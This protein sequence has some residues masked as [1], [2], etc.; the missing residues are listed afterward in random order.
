MSPQSD[1]R[2]E[3]SRKSVPSPDILRQAYDYWF[4]ELSAPDHF[5]A[6]KAEIWFK[7]S[8]VTDTHIKEKFGPQL[9]AIANANWPM[10]EMARQERVGLVIFLDQ[11]PRNIFRDSADA[12]AYDPV[13]RRVATALSGNNFSEYFPVEQLFLLLPFEHSESLA[14]QEQ[15]VELMTA[16]AEKAP[17]E[18]T[19]YPIA[20]DAAIKHR[21][22][23]RRFG[24][25]PHRNAVLGR[26]ST[27]EEIAF[28][29][30]HGRG[31]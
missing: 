23:I 3:N 12:F 17:P 29:K 13:A 24:R 11:F 31:Y 9:N 6:D 19:F 14:D 5:P 8:D 28:A 16:L 18:N 26:T 10:P 7:Q 27:A 22:L 4:G 1:H 15:A 25:F 30:E 20:L 2:R 21:D